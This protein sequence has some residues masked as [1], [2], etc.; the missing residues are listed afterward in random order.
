MALHGL[1]DEVTG[2]LLATAID[3]AAPPTPG[4][5]RTPA[6]RRLDGLNRPGFSGG[7]VLPAAGS[8]SALLCGS[9][10]LLLRRVGCC[11]STRGVGGC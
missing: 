7:R 6:R 4:D 5:T 11:R 10:S 1:A 8:Q 3:T 9:R 2:A